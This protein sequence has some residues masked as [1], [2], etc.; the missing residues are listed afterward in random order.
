MKPISTSNRYTRLL[1]LFTLIV[2]TVLYSPV[3]EAQ[4]MYWTDIDTDKIQ[5]A[6]LAGS[7]VEDL[8]TG[9][10]IPR[11]IALDLINSK[12]YWIDLGTGKIQRANLDGSNVEDLVTTG[13]SGPFGIALDLINSKMYWTDFGT[14]KIQ[15]ANLDGSNVEDL[16]TTGLIPF[17]DS[18]TP[19]FRISQE[20]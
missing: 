16:V 4:Q 12:M 20:L 14:E 17:A 10:S 6:N 3:I 15:R 11:G 19:I 7:N 5:R 2:C 8:V 9:L 18:N 13:L 1:S